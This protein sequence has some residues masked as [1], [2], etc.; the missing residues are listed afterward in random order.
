MTTTIETI[1]DIIAEKRS[2]IELIK[3]EL[4]NEI[5]NCIY[6]NDIEVEVNDWSTSIIT[7]TKG[8]RNKV[9]IYHD[10]SFSRER[11][12]EIGWFASTLNIDNDKYNYAEYLVVLGQVAQAMKNG[13]KEIFVKYLDKIDTIIGQIRK[14]ENDYRDQKYVE[15]RIKI[16]EKL[17]TT[18]VIKMNNDCVYRKSSR[19]YI[20]YNEILLNKGKKNYKVTFKLG[21]Q[22]KELSFDENTLIS[23]LY[24][25]KNHISEL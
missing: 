5:K 2:Q 21:D 1:K 19:T 10:K 14:I 4:I 6:V 17:D 8:N 16:K 18:N 15:D 13:L 22:S 12:F 23:I 11:R 24:Q 25:N 3:N 20:H 9:S 7:D